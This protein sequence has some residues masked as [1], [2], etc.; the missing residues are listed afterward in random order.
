MTSLE[1]LAFK[2]IVAPPRVAIDALGATGTHRSSQTS[3]PIATSPK[4]V[5]EHR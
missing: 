3:M 4:P 5:S 1:A 2:M